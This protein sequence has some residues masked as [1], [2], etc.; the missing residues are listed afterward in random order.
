[1]LTVIAFALILC[2]IQMLLQCKLRKLMV[3]L[4]FYTCSTVCSLGLSE[5]MHDIA[6]GEVFEHVKSLNM[7]AVHVLSLLHDLSKV[8]CKLML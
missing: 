2:K 6:D 5:T 3:L 1:M 4:L 8:V 7:S